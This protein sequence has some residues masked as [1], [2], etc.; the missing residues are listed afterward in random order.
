MAHRLSYELHVGKIPP[1]MVVCHRCD[2]PPCVNPK[3]LFLGTS[4]DNMRD[5]DSK[6][7]LAFGERHGNAKLT[8]DDV[9]EIRRLRGEYLA[10]NPTHSKWNNDATTQGTYR[11]LAARFGI[12]EAAVEF[13]C[14]RKW[15][16]H[17]I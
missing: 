5:R 1:G 17:V 10:A 4:A 3:H 2:N 9:R 12:T 16:R 11:A 15:W 13:V 14:L 7:R 8:D 6:H